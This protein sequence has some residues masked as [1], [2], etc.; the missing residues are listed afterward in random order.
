MD[1]V[2]VWGGALPWHMGPNLRGRVCTQGTRRACTRQLFGLFPIPTLVEPLRRQ[3]LCSQSAH[4]WAPEKAVV[5]ELGLIL[6]PRVLGRQPGGLW[7]PCL[8]PL[9]FGAFEGVSTIKSSP[10]ARPCILTTASKRWKSRA[11]STKS[12]E[13]R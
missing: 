2:N 9:H 1:L 5:R 12:R 7:V 10:K 13:P 3:R 4:F 8:L 6:S 11:P